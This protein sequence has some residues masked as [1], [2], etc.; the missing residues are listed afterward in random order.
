MKKILPLF[1]FLLLSVVAMAGETKTFY[2]NVHWSGDPSITGDNANGKYDFFSNI[3]ITDNEDG[4]YD[5]CIEYTKIWVNCGSITFRNVQGTTANGFT[6]LTSNG[7]KLT[8]EVVGSEFN[9]GETTMTVEGAFNSDNAYL[10][11]SG[12]FQGWGDNP[13]TITVGAPVEADPVI[14]TVSSEVTFADATVPHAADQIYVIPRF[15]NRY[16]IIYKNFTFSE[17]N[18][19]MGDYLVDGIPTHTEDDGY[20]YFDYEGSA[21]LDNLGDW[22]VGVGFNKSSVVPVKIKGKFNDTSIEGEAV[23]QVSYAATATVKFSSVANGINAISAGN[24]T[25]EVFSATGMKLDTLQK[26]L[27]I[28]RTNGK[29]KKV[30]V[31]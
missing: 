29:V 15:E 25:S 30:L 22:A 28:V 6:T 1:L 23:Y 4:T 11:L 2:E 12:T 7:E 16:K 20:T 31:K 27:N 5:V 14:Y 17:A 13:F 26:G 3:N 19:V 9:R 24:T 10:Y 18:E 8:A 21:M